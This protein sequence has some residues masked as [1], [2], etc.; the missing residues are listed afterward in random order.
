MSFSREVKEEIKEHISKARHCRIAEIAALFA[1]HGKIGTDEDGQ[2]FL[3]FSTENLTVVSKYFIL[4]R[5]TFGFAMQASAVTGARGKRTAQYHVVIRRQADVRMFLKACKIMNEAGDWIQ[6]NSI[7]NSKLLQQNCCKRAFVRGVFLASGS[8]TDPD[9]GYHFELVVGNRRWAEDLV[10]ILAA[11]RVEARIAERKRNYIVYVKEGAQIVD[12]LNVMEAHVALMR[13]ENVRI[14]KEMRNSINR[15]VNC[16]TANIRKTVSAAARQ[17]ED[18]YYIRDEVGLGT[19]PEGLVGIARLRMENPDAS[20]KE[21]G[22]MLEP[23]I[24]KSGVNHRL[25]KL[26]EIANESRQHK[27]E[28]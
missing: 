27:E 16:E 14:L 13:F 20:L 11:F 22:A 23:P 3:N 2:A 26:S 12:L 19:L 1:I 24:G 15:Q 8:V 4:I 6:G 10:H 18:I 7:V 5:K 21:L 9:C 28:K 17:M 25:R